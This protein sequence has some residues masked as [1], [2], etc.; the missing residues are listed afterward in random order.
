MKRPY[1]IIALLVLLLSACA[2]DSAVR[3]IRLVPE[4]QLGNG[5][6]RISG[7]EGSR[8]LSWSPTS[9]VLA[10]LIGTDPYPAPDCPPAP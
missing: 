2:T 7:L 4:P 1:L 6:Y 8:R 3:T 5:V 10:G 9:D